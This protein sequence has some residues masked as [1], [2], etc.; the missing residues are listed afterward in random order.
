[1]LVNNIFPIQVW[2][3]RCQTWDN[4][5]SRSHICHGCKRKEPNSEGGSPPPKLP[6]SGLRS[7][8]VSSPTLELKKLQNIIKVRGANGVLSL[9]SKFLLAVLLCILLVCPA[10]QPTLTVGLSKHFFQIF[11][12]SVT[13]KPCYHTIVG[14]L[15]LGPGSWLGQGGQIATEEKNIKLERISPWSQSIHQGSLWSSGAFIVRKHGP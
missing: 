11:N 3:I 9:K 6:R 1:M 2:Q 8:S 14:V 12:H 15:I 13:R 4:K 7:S 10:L 5:T